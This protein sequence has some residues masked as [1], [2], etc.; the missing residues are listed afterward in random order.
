MVSEEIRDRRIRLQ[1]FEWLKKQVEIHGDVLPRDILSVGFEFEGNRVPLVGASGIWK[2]K[3]I[4]AIPISIT[5]APEGPYDDSFSEDGLLLY[6]YRGT[7]PQHRDNV[8]LRNAMRGQVPLVY[9][10]GIVKGRYLAV[11]PVFIV[12]DHPESLTFT[13][14]V[15]EARFTSIHIEGDWEDLRIAESEKDKAR[16]EYVT[17]IVRVRLHQRSFRERVLKAY[18]E[19]CSLCKLRHWELLDAAHIIPDTEPG[20]DPI[21]PNGIA[22]CKLHHAAFDKHFI[23]IRP[24]FTVEVRDDILRETD[25]PM[26]QHGLQDLHNGRIILPRDRRLRPNIELLGRRY[27]RFREA[28]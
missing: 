17:S 18:R 1:A 21:V 22:L 25:G 7:D 15:D 10:H 19:Q 20:G 27:K 9:F 13:V 4:S 12:H 2:P 16:R 26:L 23:G 14:A 3:E 8:G 11:W 24:D 28:G 6:K 5:T